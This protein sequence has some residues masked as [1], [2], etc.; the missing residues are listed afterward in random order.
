MGGEH[1]A[2]A[3]RGDGKEEAS[4]GPRDGL[5]GPVNVAFSPDGTMCAAAHVQAYAT[6]WTWRAASC[7]VY[8]GGRSPPDGPRESAG[9]RGRRTVER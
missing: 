2:T 4:V 1:P 5:R 3:T 8:W 9:W 6:V 7:C